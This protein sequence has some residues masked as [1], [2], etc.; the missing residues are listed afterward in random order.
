LI[1]EKKGAARCMLF[2]GEKTTIW[3]EVIRANTR[4]L[5]RLDRCL[6]NHSGM[7]LAEYGVL[8]VLSGG[9]ADGVRM[10]QLAEMAM[11]SKSRLSHCVDRLVGMGW[12]ERSRVPG[13]KR[14]LLAKLTP[15]GVTRLR[16]AAPLHQAD[17]RTYFIEAI[18]S[19]QYV[20]AYE[21]AKAV[22]GALDQ[23]PL[24][25]SAGKVS[26][27]RGFTATLGD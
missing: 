8:T 21:I 25:A 15:E 22:N 19:D 1:Q 20:V 24:D 12:V 26:N 27:R 17:V 9:G 3:N 11:L 2:D 18:T 10:T 14:G 7:S 4:F 16:E 5:E 13:D 6:D 23:F